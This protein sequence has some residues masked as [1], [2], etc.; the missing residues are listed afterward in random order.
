[1]KTSLG[2]L[3]FLILVLL[4][5]ST[6]TEPD[7][8]KYYE[9]LSNLDAKQTIEKANE[10][11]KSATKISSY[12]NTEQVVIE[13]PDGKVVTKN[14]PDDLFYLAVAPYIN[15]THDCLIHYPSSC[16]GEMKLKNVKVTA[17]DEDGSI[18]IDEFVSTLSNGF[19][20]L[21][22]PRNKNI[23]LTIVDGNK[24]GNETLSTMIDSRTCVTTIKLD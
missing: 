20:E 17:K 24:S 4:G 3:L 2:G 6:S 5:C 9:S 14:L 18:I 23:N 11:G 1:M 21:W 15:T 16:S 12:I 8:N 13:F 19:F 10:W 7:Y 22:L